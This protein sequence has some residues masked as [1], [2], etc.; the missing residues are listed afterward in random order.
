MKRMLFG[1]CLALMPITMM[2][3]QLHKMWV[4]MPTSVAG[5]LEKSVRQELLDLKEMKK[6]AVI[7][8]LL[9]EES[10]I[11]TLTNDFLLA[12]LS[13]VST[14]QMKMLP[15]ANGDS[16]LCLVQTFMGPTPESIISF[17]TSDWKTLSM[18][19]MQLDVELQKPSDMSL[20]DFNKLQAQ[21]DPKLLSFTLSPSSNELVVT[22]S[23]VFVSEVEKS[24]MKA[25][26]LQRKFKWDGKTFN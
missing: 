21:F 10:R 9:G 22:L 2:A 26:V 8:G 24:N 13:K 19:E 12:N 15:A 17:Y 6:T 16:L 23:P 5:P 25:L 1:L 4:N 3:Q 11:D 14:L 7:E 18:P 20:E